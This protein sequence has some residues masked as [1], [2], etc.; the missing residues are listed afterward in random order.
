MHALGSRHKAASVVANDDLTV[1]NTAGGISVKLVH[2]RPLPIF[3]RF[4]FIFIFMLLFAY[5]A[6]F[7]N[8]PSYHSLTHGGCLQIQKNVAHFER[9][10]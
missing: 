10:L 2:L 6:K 5:F 1:V 4:D 8:L 7:N 3:T 9:A